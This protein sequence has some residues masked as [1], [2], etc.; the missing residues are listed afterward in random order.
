M[1]PERKVYKS[2]KPED[3]SSYFR[4]L[5]SKLTLSYLEMFCRNET[6]LLLID[7]IQN[8]P[9]SRTKIPIYDYTEF[10]FSYNKE[11]RIAGAEESWISELHEAVIAFLKPKRYALKTIGVIENGRR[12]TTQ[13]RV[14][15]TIIPG[16]LLVDTVTMS[17]IPNVNQHSVEIMPPGYVDYLSDEILREKGY[18]FGPSS[19]FT[20]N[21]PIRHP[22][23]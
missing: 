7:A 10:A 14:A 17:H 5:R 6:I 12:K 2:V 8:N 9:S 20:R 16:L 3:A 1:S 18:T 19:H 13:V 4:S 22:K 23:Q 15:T 11:R 21:H